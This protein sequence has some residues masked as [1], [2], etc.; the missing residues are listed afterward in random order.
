MS[1]RHL[2]GKCF[3][4]RG[5]QERRELSLSQLEHASNHS[6]YFYHE[7]SS[8]NKQGGLRQ[9]RV[10]HKVVTIVSN[11]AMNE[12]CSVFILDC[13][14][15]KLAEEAKRKDLFY[16]RPLTNVTKGSVSWYSIVLF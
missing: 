8:K 15:S 3:C 9:M 4:L 5:G 7:N 13:Y 2:H 12:R 10:D 11:P 1:T 6:R 16:C 14:I